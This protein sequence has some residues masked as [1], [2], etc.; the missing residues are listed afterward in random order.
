ME[1]IKFDGKLFKIAVLIFKGNS[2]YRF[3]GRSLKKPF[4]IDTNR[5]VKGQKLYGRTKINLSN[6]FLDSAFMKE[7]LGYDVYRAAGI[8][9]P[10]VG[11]AAVTL[12]VEGITKKKHLGVYCLIE[13]VDD[14]YLSRNFGTDTNDK[15]L[16]KPE[17]VDDWEYFGDDPKAYERYNIKYGKENIELIHRFSELLK[18]IE[19]GSDKAF[20]EQIENR[21]DQLRGLPRRNINSRQYR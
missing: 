14:H 21:L 6:A 18:L 11:W 9:T 5:F 20:E 3:A 13:Q 4:K 17:A 19:K 1:Y 7:K 8:P 15:L 10:G 2:S 12:T 16:M